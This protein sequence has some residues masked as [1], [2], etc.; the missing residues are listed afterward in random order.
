MRNIILEKGA[1]TASQ[2]PYKIIYIS[3][4]KARGRFILNEEALEAMLAEFEAES[5]CLEDFS[6]KEQVTL[7]QRTR[8]LISIHG[9]GLTNMMFMQEGG[10]VIEILPRKNGIF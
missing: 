5:V 9:A 2:P 4:R 7:M 8:L 6:F 3:R 10:T 1:F